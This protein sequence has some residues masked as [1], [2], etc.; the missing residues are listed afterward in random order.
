MCDGTLLTIKDAANNWAT[1]KDNTYVWS[2][3]K[4]KNVIP[5]KLIWVGITKE[6][7]KFIEVTLDDGQTI[8]TTPEHKWLLRDNTSVEAKNLK[9]ND[10]IMPFYAEPNT[11][12]TAR[13]SSYD[14]FYLNIYQ[15][16]KNTW[17][18]AH[19]I[20]GE[21]KYGE[22]GWPNITHH[23]NHVKYNN[24]PD[25]LIK[26]TQEEHADL[27]RDII[28]KYNKSEAGR[29][30]SKE[31]FIKTHQEHDFS[32]IAKDLW[33]NKD[34]R[35]K[36]IDKLTFKIDSKLINFIGLALNE[37]TTEAREH[38]IRNWLNNNDDFKAYLCSLNS[39]FKNGFNDKLTKGQ[40]LHA[41][42]SINF[43]NLRDVKDF[44]VAIKAPWD[45]IT[46]Y[47]SDVKPKTQKQII[48]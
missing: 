3:D 16:G 15:P 31:T 11:E 33:K 6:K 35:E 41:L 38:E 2:L 10:S 42:R 17:K 14:N 39:D 8:R 29:Q 45:K 40:F 46:T 19:R 24:H 1:H 13:H 34:I 21:W 18:S 37:L 12:L 5:T 44:Y 20:V 7:T 4:N 23:K 30:K 25:N 48:S 22:Y 43:N 36:R 28:V 27:H 26:M 32:K 47:C 9:V